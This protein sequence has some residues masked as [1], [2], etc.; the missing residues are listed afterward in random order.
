MQKSIFIFHFHHHFSSRRLR[1]SRLACNSTPSAIPTEPTI[2]IPTPPP[3]K[4]ACTS[5]DLQPTPGPDAPSLFPPVSAEDYV[6]GSDD[7]AVTLVIYN[8]FQCTDCNY[9]PLS[10]ESIRK[11]TRMMCASSTVIIL[12]QPFSTKANW[13]RA[14]QKPLPIRINSGKCTICCLKCKPNGSIC[15]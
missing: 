7:A 2:I 12:T 15:R 10:Q 1:S 9:L 8:D 3:T 6:R 13:P 4:P 14:L 5:L 11:S